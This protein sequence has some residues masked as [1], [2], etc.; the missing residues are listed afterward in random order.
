MVDFSR[1]IS[2]FKN[3]WP[4]GYCEGDPLDPLLGSTY[5]ELGYISVIHVIY[6]CCI[7]PYINSNTVALEIGPG[8][9]CWTKSMLP[10]KEIYAL[11][12]CS[13]KDNG[14]FDYL[15]HPA[16]VKYFQVKDFSCD[17]LP[18]DYFT[19]MFSFGCLC[20]VSFEGTTEYAK[21]IF[22]KLKSGSHCFWMIADYNKYNA[23][24][25]NSN[26]LSIDVRRGFSKKSSVNTT[27]VKDV[28]NEPWP[29][30]WYDAGI[31]RTCAMLEGVGYKII[32]RDVGASLRDPIIHFV[33]L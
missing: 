19:Y 23:A 22:A 3:L 32:D 26:A 1:E 31:D 28:N 24:T 29:G 18:P 30:R 21:N 6:L 7:K 9:G 20:H 5:G 11:D 8:R 27:P 33:K 12:A 14:F 4:G 25:A 13:E 16:H 17:M 15:G 10:S 2:Q